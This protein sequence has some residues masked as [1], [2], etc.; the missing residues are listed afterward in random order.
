[1]SRYLLAPE[2]SADLEEIFDYIALDN[3][4]AAR[5]VLDVLQAAMK[6]LAATPGLGHLRLDLAPEPLRFWQVY[7]YLI[8]YRP[9]EKPLQ[10]AR[11]LHAARDVRA[12]LETDE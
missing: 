8:V 11:V 5:R 4:D 3:S 9:D 2:A 1:M 6:K 10:V 12:I 7:S